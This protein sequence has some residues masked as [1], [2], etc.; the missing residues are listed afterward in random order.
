MGSG[1]TAS[2]DCY[3]GNYQQCHKLALSNY[4]NIS[5]QS[6]YCCSQT[7]TLAGKLP[8]E[9]QKKTRETISD[10]NPFV[11]THGDLEV[12]DND[13]EQG[14]DENQPSKN[15]SLDLFESG[16]V[17]EMVVLRGPVKDDPAPFWLGKVIW[18]VGSTGLRIK[19]QWFKP[20]TSSSSTSSLLLG[21][22]FQNMN[23]SE[24]L[25]STGAV[26]SSFQNLKKAGRLPVT[27][28]RVIQKER[29]V[30]DRLK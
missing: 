1:N 21:K 14:E 2:H 4:D 12:F 29:S 16:Q 20:V 27:T 19:V 8:I 9:A 25:V 5:S 3:K 13:A 15:K 10:S 11:H 18:F 24:S 22:Y 6:V 28:L 26:L 17:G 7:L 23:E 30:I